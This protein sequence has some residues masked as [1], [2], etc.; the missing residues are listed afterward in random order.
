[1]SKAL[2]KRAVEVILGL[3]E[4]M[5]EIT[6]EAV[7]D[8]VRPHYMFDPRA[9]RERE[10]RRKANRLMAKFRDDQGVRTCFSYTDNTGQSK[11]VNIEKTKDIEAVIAVNEQINNKFYGLSNAKRKVNARLL[12]LAGQMKLFGNE[13]EGAL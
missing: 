11:Y 5:D 8:V 6:T 4:E 13:D 12:E 10:I 2:D 1:V 9:A 3:M 7:M